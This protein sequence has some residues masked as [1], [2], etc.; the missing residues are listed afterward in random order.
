MLDGELRVERLTS[1][2]A[3]SLWLGVPL[4]YFFDKLDDEVVRLFGEA[5]AALERGGH[6]VGDVSIA[7]AERTADTYLHIVL[8]EASWYHAPLLE[9]HADKY[10]PGVRLRLEMGRYILAED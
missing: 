9:Q 10:S 5:R 3:A 6:T 7:H 2:R 8:P 4:P 1:G